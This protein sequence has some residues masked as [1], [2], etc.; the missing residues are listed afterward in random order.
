VSPASLVSF[1]HNR[2]S[3]DCRHVGQTVQL[4]VYAQRI[5]VV[6]QGEVI[7][8]HRRRFGRG[9]TVFDPWHYLPALERKPGA[10]RNG[11]P[12]REWGL[13][14][15]LDRIG[16]LL[17][18]RY[19][20]GDRQYVGILQAVPLCGIEAVEAACTQALAAGTISK[21]VVLNLLHR[22]RPEQTTQAIELPAELNLKQPPIADCRRYDRML[23]E[24]AHGAQ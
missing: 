13:P 20:D 9:K 6:S 19:P 22:G 16:R 24:A 12:F 21:E 17:Q 11:A 3:V 7:A 23:R 1:D 14:E 15:S 5:V 18:Q 10:L 2:Y 4:R 8:E